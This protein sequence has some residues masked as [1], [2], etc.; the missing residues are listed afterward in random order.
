MQKHF[1]IRMPPIVAALGVAV[2][3]SGCHRVIIDSGLEPSPQVH[4]EEWNQAFAHAIYPAQVDA[5]AFCGGRWARVEVKQ[6]F[7]NLV[8][9]SITF[10]IISPMDVRVVC[11]ATRSAADGQP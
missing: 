8:V 11:A 10:G 5:S 7:L 6:S 4:H 2:L 1:R 3:L 9:E